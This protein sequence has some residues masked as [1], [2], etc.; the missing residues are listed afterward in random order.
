MM[1]WMKGKASLFVQCTFARS[2]PTIIDLKFDALRFKSKPVQNLKT[3]G[4]QTQV[5]A[6]A[7]IAGTRRHR[8]AIAEGYFNHFQSVRDLF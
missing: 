6:P 1:H 7:V 4:L 8:T 5:T 3:A 2:L